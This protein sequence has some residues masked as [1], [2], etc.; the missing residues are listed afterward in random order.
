MRFSVYLSEDNNILIND[1]FYGTFSNNIIEYNDGIVN[2][3]DLKN[4]LFK[5]EYLIFDFNNCTCIYNYD[6]YKMCI[7][8][9]V[10]DKNISDCNVFVKYK[11]I[12]TG[13][14]YEYRVSWKK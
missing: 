12:E 11:I 5:R 10:I 14:I 7:D 1:D 4:C 2:S 6:N 9:E 3:F 13:H 8:L